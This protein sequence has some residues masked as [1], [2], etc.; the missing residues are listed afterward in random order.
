MK[1]YTE[2]DG[3]F[4]SVDASAKFDNESLD[5][6]FI[7]MSHEYEDIK[8]DIEVWLPK[9]KING[10]ISGH[11]YSWIGVNKATKEKFGNRVYAIHGD[12]WIF[13]KTGEN[14]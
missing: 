8:Q 12:C 11:D 1:K 14:S 9:V 6:V 5:V 13:H 3:W 7:D 2:I 10:Y 4:N